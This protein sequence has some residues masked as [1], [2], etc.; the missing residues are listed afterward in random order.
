MVLSLAHAR[1]CLDCDCL[2]DQAACPWCDRKDTVPIAG[3]FRPLEERAAAGGRLRK[4]GAGPARRFILVVQHQQRELYRVLRQALEGTG[5]E[6]LYDR[7][8][9]QR[10]RIAAGPA[11]EERRRTDRRRT[12]PGAVVFETTAGPPALAAPLRP[13]A[14]RADV[15]V[16]R[17]RRRQPTPV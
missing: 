15:P 10:R 13:P 1:V 2:T 12:R 6:V 16:V 17:S 5:V 4:T 8:I 11:A 3:W 9:G 14:G 7:R